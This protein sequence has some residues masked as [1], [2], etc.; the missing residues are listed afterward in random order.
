[1]QT[2][3]VN[4]FRFIGPFLADLFLVKVKV[5]IGIIEIIVIVGLKF[6]LLVVPKLLLIIVVIGLAISVGF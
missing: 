1:M 3:F 4:L 2:V 6:R 5:I